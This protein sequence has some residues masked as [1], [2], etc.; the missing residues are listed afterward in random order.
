MQ[1]PNTISKTIYAGYG[2]TGATGIAVSP[3]GSRLFCKL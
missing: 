3:D 2:T 1:I